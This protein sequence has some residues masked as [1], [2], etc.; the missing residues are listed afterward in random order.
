TVIL[1][2]INRGESGAVGFLLSTVYDELHRLAAGQMGRERQDHTL[3]P[4]ALVHEAYLRLVGDVPLQFKNRAHFFGAAAEAM[5]R[6]LV[7]HARARLAAKRGGGRDRTPL[8]DLVDSNEQT[9]EDLIAIDEA[10]TKLSQV[11]AQKHRIVEL[12]FF[13]G[14]TAEETA[15]VMDI[16]L[17]TVHRDWRFSKAWLFREIAG[18]S[19]RRIDVGSTGDSR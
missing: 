4:T 10:L 16:S 6:I 15:E 3:Q 1:D 2:R 13:A 8:S 17:R 19:R 7:D 5:R 12:R 11:D 14:L 9:P 18:A